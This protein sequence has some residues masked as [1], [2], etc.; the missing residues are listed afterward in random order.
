MKTSKKHLEP[1]AMKKRELIEE[2]Y[3]LI[4]SEAD[5]PNAFFDVQISKES[6]KKSRIIANR[7]GIEL[8]ATEL[9]MEAENMFDETYGPDHGNYSEPISVGKWCRRKAKVRFTELELT[10]IDLYQ[11]SLYHNEARSFRSGCFASISVYFI[12]LVYILA[13]FGAVAVIKFF[14]S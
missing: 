1:V 6:P 10:D 13:L 8:F 4:Q 11:N 5:K 7:P 2:L 12:L 9:M 14:T 3:Q